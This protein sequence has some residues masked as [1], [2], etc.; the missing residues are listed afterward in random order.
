M[1]FE[2]RIWH[3]TEEQLGIALHKRPGTNFTDAR[4]SLTRVV[5]EWKTPMFAERKRA[6][7][8]RL[9]GKEFLPFL[10]TWP[11]RTLRA[12]LRAPNVASR[13]PNAASS[14]SHLPKRR[15]PCAGYRVVVDHSFAT[16]APVVVSLLLGIRDALRST[17]CA[18]GS[19]V[20]AARY[21]CEAIVQSSIPD[22]SFVQ[23]ELLL[24]QMGLDVEV[25]DTFSQQP[26][27]HNPDT[28]V[29]SMRIRTRPR[30]D[31]PIAE[32]V[33]RVWV[34]ASLMLNTRPFEVYEGPRR[35][36]HQ[37]DVVRA[38]VRRS[39]EW[40]HTC[41]GISRD[42]DDP[43]TMYRA[44]LVHPPEITYGVLGILFKESVCWH[45]RHTLPADVGRII[46]K[47]GVV[48]RRF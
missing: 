15:D 48:L 26:H 18:G 38:M 4:R 9:C 27:P 12:S 7:K 20:G 17:L 31:V 21:E 41:F 3:A 30:H 32:F 36:L 25:L 43:L 22:R 34:A 29:T 14:S 35:A 47:Y 5:G 23:V 1:S 45:L 13:A 40:A 37:L 6:R 8:V 2:L 28:F 42:V 46:L 39:R 33:Q 16:K 19:L 44:H 11:S 24:A 10:A